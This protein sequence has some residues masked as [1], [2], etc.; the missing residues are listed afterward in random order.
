MFEVIFLLALGFVW[1]LVATIQDLRKKEVANWLNFSL[2]I[3]ALGFR[4]FYSLFSETGFSFFYQGLIGLG[5][6]FVLG[7]IFYYSRVFAGG[8]AKL[9]IALGTILPVSSSF[10][11]NLRYFVLFLLIFFFVG[12]IY[13]LIWSFCLVFKNIRAFKNKFKQLFKKKR[14]FIFIIMFLGLIFMVLGFYQSILFF[15]GLLI[16]ISPYF[17]VYAKAIDEA[18]M[19]KRVNTKDLREGDWLYSRIKIGRRYIE[20]SW[21]G[22]SKKQVSDIKKKYRFVKIRQGVVFVPVFLISF[23]VF[24]YGILLGSRIVSFILPGFF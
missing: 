17:F 6:F 23:I 11:T 1:I 8:D 15:L 3:F 4:F 16:F 20:P 9:M 13:G 5:I 22:L 12:T 24:V 7:N 21:E 10:F 19:I 18:A 14:S 2:I